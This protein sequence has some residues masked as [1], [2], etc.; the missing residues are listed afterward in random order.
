MAKKVMLAVANN[1]KLLAQSQPIL[2]YTDLYMGNIFV[3]EDN[4]AALPPDYEDIDADDKEIVLYNK[5]KAI[6]TKAY[7]VV[8]F[9]NDRVAWRAI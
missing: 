6:W 8:S 5:E 1:P 3:A 4:L 9:L 7:E 2:W